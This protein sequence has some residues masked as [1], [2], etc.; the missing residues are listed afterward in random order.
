MMH[1]PM[2]AGPA[3]PLEVVPEQ[4][5]QIRTAPH[6]HSAPAGWP[7]QMADLCGTHTCARIG[8]LDMHDYMHDRFC[9]CVCIRCTLQRRHCPLWNCRIDKYERVSY[10]RVHAC[11]STATC[12]VYAR[13]T[14]LAL[15]GLAAFCLMPPG[16]CGFPRCNFVQNCIFGAKKYHHAQEHSTSH[17]WQHT[18]HSQRPCAASLASVRRKEIS[19][20]WQPK[21]W[22]G[23]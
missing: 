23:R 14:S 20:V 19:C 16:R 8:L 18:S 4:Q 7:M 17:T 13:I 3:E 1:F 11:I 5:G 22:C 15:V 2:K 12:S 21:R 10:S 6:N 9:A